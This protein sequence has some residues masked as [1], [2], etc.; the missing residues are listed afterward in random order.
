MSGRGSIELRRRIEKI[1]VLIIDI[2]IGYE[3]KGEKILE[4]RSIEDSKKIGREKGN[5]NEIKGK[6]NKM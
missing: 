2:R 4:I 5:K 6:K 1:E 3:I